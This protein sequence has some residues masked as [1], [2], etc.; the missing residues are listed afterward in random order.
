MVIRTCDILERGKEICVATVVNVKVDV[1]GTSY[2]KAKMFRNVQDT[3]ISLVRDLNHSKDRENVL[4]HKA[5]LILHIA[6][7]F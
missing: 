4:N 5:S 3:R 6:E 2:H 1:Y 7:L